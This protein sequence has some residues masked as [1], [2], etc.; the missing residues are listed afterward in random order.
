MRWDDNDIRYVRLDLRKRGLAQG[1][2]LNELTDH[3]CCEVER[4][5]ADGIPFKKA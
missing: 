3:V 2:L 1:E 4:E 5:M